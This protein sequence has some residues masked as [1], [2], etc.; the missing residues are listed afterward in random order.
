MAI[1]IK[2][3]EVVSDDQ[4]LV[5][6]KFGPDAISFP[7][8][9]GSNSQVLT[10]D[11][12][13]NL[14]YSNRLSNVV[15]DTTPEL[16]GDLYVN[17]NNIRGSV[18]TI[19]GAEGARLRLL[20][21][22]GGQSYDPGSTGYTGTLLIGNTGDRTGLSGPAYGGNVTI[23]GGTAIQSGN[24]SYGGDVTI[25]GGFPD[26]NSS[27]RFGSVYVRDV[28]D[29]SVTASNSINLNGRTKASTIELSQNH[30]VAPVAK[31]VTA[32]STSSSTTAF[33]L[34]S[35]DQ[36]EIRSMKIVIQASN[37]DSSYYYVSELLCVHDD[38]NAYLTEYATIDTTPGGNMISV[39]A[40]LLNG[41]FIIKITPSTSDNIDYK[42]TMQQ[43]F[44]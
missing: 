36:N 11:G 17:S 37:T 41:N 28:Y 32:Y 34:A 44:V 26:G 6:V 15:E 23:Q 5:G 9:D 14:L 2:G 25:K 33:N 35:F 19:S 13:G 43:T 12:S 8:S 10:T 27:S 7:A 20:S 42:F 21:G 24:I 39:Q 40:S 22:T 3:V 29:F 30:S 16:G 1:K 4:E 38:T 18:H 31:I